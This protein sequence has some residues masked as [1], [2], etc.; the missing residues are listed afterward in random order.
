M[1]SS[2]CVLVMVV[3]SSC[4]AAQ[5]S[6]LPCQSFCGCWEDT[7]LSVAG[8]TLT[9]DGGA[10]SGIRVS[11][12]SERGAVMDVSDQSGAYNF[13]LSTQVSP[14]CGYNNCNIVRFDDPSGVL[15][16]RELTVWQLRD[17][18]GNVTLEP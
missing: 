16:S 8:N 1:R 15:Q 17:A 4:G 7:T 2:I 5:E 3:L 13:D 10:I 18:G 14:G 12:M 9:P 11:C 6:R